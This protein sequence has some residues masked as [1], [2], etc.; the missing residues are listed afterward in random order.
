MFEREGELRG[1]CKGYRAERPADV[2]LDWVVL[3]RPYGLWVSDRAMNA[4][5]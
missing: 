3:R 5:G 2:D 1:P 4:W